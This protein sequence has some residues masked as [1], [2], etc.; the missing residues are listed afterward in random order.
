MGERRVSSSLDIARSYCTPRGSA[1]GGYIP[2]DLP[3]LRL[4]GP[5]CADTGGETSRG[6]TILFYHSVFLFLFFQSKPVVVNFLDCRGSWLWGWKIIGSSGFKGWFCG[7][8]NV[9][10]ESQLWLQRYPHWT[11]FQQVMVVFCIVQSSFEKV[12]LEIKILRK[13]FFF[14]SSALTETCQRRNFTLLRYVV[15]SFDVV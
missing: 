1:V 9:V 4:P 3:R 12:H 15:I 5:H 7:S 10:S 6:W 13:Y 8:I 11:K 14:Q 2:G